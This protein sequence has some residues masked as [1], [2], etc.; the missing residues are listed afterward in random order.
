MPSNFH[1]DMSFYS[2]FMFVALNVASILKHPRTPTHNPA[3]D[4]PSADS[5]HV[6]KRTRPIGISDEVC[7]VAFSGTCFIS[8][9]YHY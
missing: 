8:I 9:P 4:Y 5:D 6:S 2:L 7:T 3:A 1:I